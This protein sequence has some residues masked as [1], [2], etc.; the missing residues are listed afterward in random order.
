MAQALIALA[1]ILLVVPAFGG[2][3]SV[4]DSDDWDSSSREI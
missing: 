2:I 4:P 3:F 1:V